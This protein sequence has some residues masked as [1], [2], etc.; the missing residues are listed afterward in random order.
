MVRLMLVL[1]HDD[2]AVFKTTLRIQD[3]PKVLPLWR[4]AQ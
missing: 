3:A 1:L 4:K 2:I